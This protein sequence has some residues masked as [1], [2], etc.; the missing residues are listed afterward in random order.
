MPPL[1]E[2]RLMQSLWAR[3]LQLCI[4]VK[5]LRSVMGTRGY[6]PMDHPDGA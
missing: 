1:V 6:D 5:V 3:L 4:V 2:L